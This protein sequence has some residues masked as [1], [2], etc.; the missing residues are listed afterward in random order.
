MICGRGDERD[1]GY[2]DSWVKLRNERMGRFDWEDLDQKN[3]SNRIGQ[4][5]SKEAR[6]LSTTEGPE[7]RDER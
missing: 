2:E 3:W 4:V 6:G 7:V 5:E 1:I